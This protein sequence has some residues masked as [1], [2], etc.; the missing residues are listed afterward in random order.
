MASSASASR[1]VIAVPDC[2]NPNRRES[3]SHRRTLVWAVVAQSSSPLCLSKRGGGKENAA[4]GETQRKHRQQSPQ[5]V[6]KARC[7]GRVGL[8]AVRD[9]CQ[10]IK[11]WRCGKPY[12]LRRRRTLRDCDTETI[13]TWLPAFENWLPVPA[14]RNGTYP[15][16]ANKLARADI[17]II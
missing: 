7:Y 16:A 17:R 4:A 1:A 12:Q 3:A 10:W 9:R 11:Q 8:L 6:V 14:R 13:K 5:A 15:S 2:R